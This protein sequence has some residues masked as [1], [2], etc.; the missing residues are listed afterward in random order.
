[1][2]ENMVNRAMQFLKCGGMHWDR[3]V[4]LSEISMKAFAEAGERLK[5]SGALRK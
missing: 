1:M 2:Y 5:I 4:M 3:F